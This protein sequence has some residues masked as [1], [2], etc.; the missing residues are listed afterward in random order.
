MKN[1]TSFTAVID[2]NYFINGIWD[3]YY[4][5]NNK[6]KNRLDKYVSF[7]KNFSARFPL[8]SFKFLPIEYKD[9]P[10]GNFI[11][12]SLNR[13]ITDRV[14]SK[15]FAVPEDT[16]LLGTMRAYLGNIIITPK[17]EWLNHH[18]LWFPINSEF[19]EIIPKDELKYFWLIYLKSDSF[20]H[21]L[22]TGSGGTRPRANPDLLSQIPVSV[23]AYNER[24]LIDNEIK[25]F[26]EKLWKEQVLLNNYI[27]KLF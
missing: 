27:E 20:L 18:N 17:S 24:K 21:N 16:L 2:Y 13:N 11:I 6:S 3:P 7:S 25:V 8:S 5:R 26:A 19:C 15:Y 4:Y 10:K 14:N 22:P 9:I 12:F 1:G 23:P